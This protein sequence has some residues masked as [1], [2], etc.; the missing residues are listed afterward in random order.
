M[1]KYLRI[2]RILTRYY[3]AWQRPLSTF[4]ML[5]LVHG[6]GALT[7]GLDHL[8]YPGFRRIPLDRPVFIIG[9]PRSGTTFLHR[10][11]LETQQQAAR[12]RQRT[13][14]HRYTPEQFGLTAERIQN[15]LAY[16]YDEYDLAP[17]P[18]GPPAQESPHAS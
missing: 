1:G 16:V 12:Q 13:S 9:N 8:I 17:A 4:G 14:S 5:K 2:Y 10:F 7:R 15:D 18:A 11:L 6:V 3:G